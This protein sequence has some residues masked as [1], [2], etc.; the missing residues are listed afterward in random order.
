ME[1][2]EG[3]KV[4]VGDGL[5]VKFGRDWEGMGPKLVIRLSQDMGVRSKPV[6]GSEWDGLGV[7]VET[8]LEPGSVMGLGTAGG[9]LVSYL[10]VGRSWRSEWR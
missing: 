9:E 1:V 7:G 8:E 10:G 5:E 4:K 3:Q 6:V 2:R